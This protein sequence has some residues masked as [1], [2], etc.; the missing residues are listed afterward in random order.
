MKMDTSVIKQP[1]MKGMENM[2]MLPMPFFTHM[3]IP[4][5]VGSYG[6]RIAALSTKN[7]ET[8]Q[9]E[10]NFQ[11]ETGLSKTVGLFLGGKGYLMMLLWKLW[12]NF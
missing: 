5:N 1:E 8:T 7:E 4:Y 11:F 2:E 10:F 3:G 6:L 12:C 9:T